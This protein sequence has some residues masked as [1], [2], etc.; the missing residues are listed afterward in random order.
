M[1]KVELLIKQSSREKVFYILKCIHECCL[2]NIRTKEVY[3]GEYV[4]SLVPES[5]SGFEDIVEMFEY[6]D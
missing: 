3:T 4:R 5:M 6:F 1:D 2:G